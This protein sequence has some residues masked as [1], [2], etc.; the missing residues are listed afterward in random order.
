[1]FLPRIQDLMCWLEALRIAICVNWSL[2]SKV[3]YISE[4]EMPELPLENIRKMGCW[5]GSVMCSFLRC[6]LKVSILH[7][8][9]FTKTLK[10]AIVSGL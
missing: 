10:N 7:K 1:M 5:S 4:L 2:N 8:R 9:V 6:L 3:T